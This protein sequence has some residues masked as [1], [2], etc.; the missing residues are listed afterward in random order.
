MTDQGRSLLGM[1][2]GG[3]ILRMHHDAP[4]HLVFP[5][6]GHVGSLEQGLL[7]DGL[8]IVNW[9]GLI[10]SKCS[11]APHEMVN[12]PRNRVIDRASR[13]VICIGA[14]NGADR[15]REPGGEA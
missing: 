1:R 12:F 14:A 6:S 15:L 4:P 8:V 9:K 11:V 7:L 5:S 3:Y 13:L 10:T 2:S